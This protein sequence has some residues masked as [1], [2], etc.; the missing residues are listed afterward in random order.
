[1]VGVLVAAA[2]GAGVAG[3]GDDEDST[4][5]GEP[6]PA[7]TAAPSGGDTAAGKV[8]F[9][10]NCAGCH[11]LADAGSGTVGPPLDGRSLSVEAVAAQVTNGGGAMPAFGDRLG[12]Q[13]IAD[14]AA[15]V[16]E[17]SGG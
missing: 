13:E 6:A 5:P 9:T 8:V 14:V 3:C 12:E 7:T 1:M 11:T 16:A 4:A 17:A 10:A 15:Y 2:L